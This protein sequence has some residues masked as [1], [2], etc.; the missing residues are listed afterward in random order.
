MRRNI[1]PPPP[2]P[3]SKRLY[4]L[5][6]RNN[7]GQPP[8]RKADID[9]ESELSD[10]DSILAL[11]KRLDA[12][13][14]ISDPSF[15][16]GTEPH[17]HGLDPS[18]F[19]ESSGTLGNGR[20]Y[21]H[22]ERNPYYGRG[23][24]LD[25]IAS[26]DQEEDEDYS[27]YTDGSGSQY[28]EE[29]D[30]RENMRH[31]PPPGVP[32]VG[33]YDDKSYG[34]R[35]G[36]YVSP[37][38][39]GGNSYSRY[40]G[41]GYN[42]KMSN[43]YNVR[44]RSRSP[45]S[46]RGRSRSPPGLSRRNSR[47][48]SPSLVKGRSKSPNG[49]NRSYSPRG[50]GSAHSQQ[51]V[52]YSRENRDSN[53]IVDRIISERNSGS[54]TK[55]TLK[56]VA[57][58][59]IV[60]IV[61]AASIGIVFA[62][63]GGN[64][65]NSAVS[66]QE[67]IQVLLPTASPT[68]IGEY[69]CPAGYKGQVPTKGCLGYVECNGMGDIEGGV[70]PCPS[71]TL[72]DIKVNTCSWAESVDCSTKPTTETASTVNSLPTSKPTSSPDT[73]AE[74][75]L[76]SVKTI[77]PTETY[78]HKLLFQGIVS[79]GDVT[80]FQQNIENYI[81]IFFSPSRDE[82][83]GED[84]AALAINDHVLN[85]LSDVKVGLTIKKFEWS[86]ATRLRGLQENLELIMIYDQNTEYSTTDASITVGTVVRHPYEKQYEPTLIDYLKSTDESFA[87]LTSVVFLEGDDAGSSSSET[88]A[89][90]TSLNSSGEPSMSPSVISSTP[91]PT[92]VVVT[93]SPTLS[94]E[95]SAPTNRATTPELPMKLTP[96]LSPTGVFVAFPQYATVQGY[97]WIDS[98]G[99]G[100][101]QSSEPPATGTF[102]NLRFCA[103]DKWVATTTSNGSGQ[104]QFLGVAEGEYFVEFFPP[105]NNY[106]FTKPMMGSN[107]TA[108]HS[109][110][111]LLSGR[112]PCVVVDS[113]FSQLINAGYVLVD[114]SGELTTTPTASP[115]SDTFKYC[116][117]VTTTSG[118]QSFDFFGCSTRCAQDSDCS[119][120][121]RCVLSKS[122]SNED[123]QA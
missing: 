117:Q 11:A 9:D 4:D 81:V 109:D 121:L 22:P 66:N 73:A 55:R 52:R 86:G 47:S 59:L 110:V 69:H 70:L 83:L 42:T 89:P 84:M 34:P 10:N 112:T 41:A 8:T 87:S 1:P 77:G 114:S 71:G 13:S 111:T 115:E 49:R 32:R 92:I 113:S 88:A 74:T 123:G 7:H 39:G 116:A 29:S 48:Q 58:P 12:S 118:N 105:S 107:T 17:R 94:T 85:S 101:F 21:D 95:T 6:S 119:D 23:A 20:F 2:R 72:Y 15:I 37:V 30:R 40:S 60:V 56:L 99:D 122:C 79:P 3:L 80:T 76:E 61:I 27:V 120:D 25:S 75:E 33:H 104:Y 91:A 90:I 16:E 18:G 5:D 54:D 57:V 51:G 35:V 68:Y 26:N 100:L 36:H 67:K 24:D 78:N 106:E 62:T 53:D 50:R 28:T 46:P 82:Y 65:K 63:R 14:V 102:A 96:T 93:E 108:L 98:N 43:N 38:G 64:E 97:M 45:P 103:D 44:A 31:V 19:A